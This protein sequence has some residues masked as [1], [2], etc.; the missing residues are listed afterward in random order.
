MIELPHSEDSERAVIGGLI[1]N[2]QWYWEVAAILEPDD[3]YSIAFREMFR[4]IGKLVDEKKPVHHGLIAEEMKAA[5]TYR[6]I[7]DALIFS[8][9]TD[10]CVACAAVHHAKTVRDFSRK[11]KIIVAARQAEQIAMDP[12]KSIDDCISEVRNAVSLALEEKPD[13][14]CLLLSET[15]QEAIRDITSGESMKGV[16]MT[17]LRTVDEKFGGLYPRI[18]TV[19]AGRPGMGKS[20]FLVNLAMRVAFAGK[21]VYFVTLEDDRFFIQSRILANLCKI[22]NTRVIRGFLGPEEMDRVKS[23][24][25]VISSMKITIDDGGPF[26]SDQVR[27]RC[28]AHCA[29]NPCDLIIIDHLGHVSDQGRTEYEIATKAIKILS[30]IPKETGKPVLL[31]AQLNRGLENRSAK[32]PNL[33]DLRGTGEIEQRARAVWFLHRPRVYDDK[34]DPN[35]LDFIVAKANHGR[36]GKQKLWVDLS[37]MRIQDETPLLP[38]SS[39][40]ENTERY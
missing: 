1:L 28:A 4:S 32:E 23:Q 14:R 6:Y 17:G 30:G 39:V 19:L 13:D 10:D 27:R 9:L 22:D 8:T 31:A 2:S 20:T 24:E 21:H 34:A 25:L 16:V 18:L 7:H 35:E 3:F 12:S 26:T 15:I 37:T 33:A 29:A 38:Q 36:T 5:K 11:R 40:A